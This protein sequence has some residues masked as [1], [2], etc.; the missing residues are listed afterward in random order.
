[1]QG[2]KLR[3]I[4]PRLL[5]AISTSVPALLT[6][7]VFLEQPALAQVTDSG[8]SA[9]NLPGELPGPSQWADE[10]K[11][12]AVKSDTTEWVAPTKTVE[13][14]T[15]LTNSGKPVV[16]T[17][18]L[19][20]GDMP[21]GVGSSTIKNSCAITD[22]KSTGTVCC[23]CLY[24]VDRYHPE[25]RFKKAC[26]ALR[27][28]NE[29]T[30]DLPARCDKWL[31]LPVAGQSESEFIE[32][33][34]IN[35]CESYMAG[36]DR[37][38]VWYNGHGSPAAGISF[39]NLTYRL[40]LQTRDR[41]LNA[42]TRSCE[43]F[44]NY[45]EL[46]RHLEKLQ[47]ERP[48]ARLSLY[49]SRRLA[50][51][52][53]RGRIGDTGDPVVIEVNGTL[54]TSTCT[55]PACEF[56]MGCWGV[57]SIT[58]GLDRSDRDAENDCR[59]TACSAS[60][61]SVKQRRCCPKADPSRSDGRSLGTWVAADQPC[62]TCIGSC[63]LLT[64]SGDDLDCKDNRTLEQCQN[65]RGEFPCV[66]EA[67]I[68]SFNAGKRCSDNPCA[69]AGGYC[70]M[71]GAQGEVVGQCKFAGRRQ[72]CGDSL[73][74]SLLF[75]AEQTRDR[76][77]SCESPVIQQQCRIENFPP[78]AAFVPRFN[79]FTYTEIRPVVSLVHQELL[80]NGQRCMDL[81]AFRV[82]NFNRWSELD[83][84]YTCIQKG[85]RIGDPF[86]DSSIA[87]KCYE[88]G[89]LVLLE[90]PDATPGVPKIFLTK[91]AAE[92]ACKTRCEDV[93]GVTELEGK[94]QGWRIYNPL[95]GGELVT[96]PPAPLDGE[97][98][99]WRDCREVV[100]GS[101]CLPTE[102]SCPAE[103]ETPSIGIFYQH[104]DLETR[105]SRRYCN[106]K[107]EGQGYECPRPAPVPTTI[108]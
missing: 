17:V 84:V 18:P 35:R 25:E 56:G 6:D 32:Q 8:T 89:D 10:A 45:E 3:S 33:S 52:C 91:S 44:R 69:S 49:G 78:I 58:G 76:S 5:F 108:G 21:S 51:M 105:S 98:M 42:D 99:S 93:A 97:Q 90:N 77:L 63:C 38:I 14:S 80:D 7:A 92:A 26:E 62:P 12:G 65:Q 54:D 4:L 100:N 71:R 102:G 41:T 22:P 96:T 48:C 79:I 43:T 64:N 59:L 29:G 103:K 73:T 101:Q 75:F 31:M 1:M 55:L 95:D 60:D 104:Y 16:E 36:C 30:A 107:V 40:C 94:V 28:D 23:L 85:L 86:A 20:F 9:G 82:E 61:G 68:T 67:G 24:Q 87:N 37:G 81:G 19:V 57:S 106:F 66:F 11:S 88:T 46:Q 27:R 53:Q 2:Y 39:L 34:F 47:R 70:C 50:T 74:G 13:G 83:K 15:A 72:D